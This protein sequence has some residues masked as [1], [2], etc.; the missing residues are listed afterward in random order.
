MEGTRHIVIILHLAI[1][2]TA[3]PVVLLLLLLTK[4]EVR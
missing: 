3:I 2:R 4:A 1:T